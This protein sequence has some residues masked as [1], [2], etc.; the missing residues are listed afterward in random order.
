MLFVNSDLNFN[1]NLNSNFNFNSVC[2]LIKIERLI[3]KRNRYSAKGIELWLWFWQL[4][5]IWLICPSVSQ[6]KE[7][8]FLLLLLLLSPAFKRQTDFCVCHAQTVFL[9]NRFFPTFNEPISELTVAPPSS[10]NRHLWDLNILVLLFATFVSSQKSFSLF[11]FLKVALF[12][13]L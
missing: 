10:I 13:L 3:T 2:L 6:Q 5:C 9:T 1:F 7:N 4:I 11:L 12:L 8:T